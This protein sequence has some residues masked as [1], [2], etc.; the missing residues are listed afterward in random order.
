MSEVRPRCAR[1]LADVEE[2]AVGAMPL[3]QFGSDAKGERKLASRRD[4]LAITGELVCGGSEGGV[5]GRQGGTKGRRTGRSRE[6]CLYSR[7]LYSAV[8]YSAVEGVHLVPN[9]SG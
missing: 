7:V 8:L 3:L 5:G 9:V 1:L 2:A 4:G 6:P